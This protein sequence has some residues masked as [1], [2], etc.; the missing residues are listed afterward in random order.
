MRVWRLTRRRL[1][2]LSGEG[3]RRHGGRWTSPGRPVVYTAQSAALALL[4]VLVHLDLGPGL[5]PSDYVLMEIDAPDDL[6]VLRTGAR[7]AL[8]FETSRR[9]GDAWIAAGLEPVLAL[10]SVIVPRETNYLLNPR[11]AAAARLR[12]VGIDDFAIDRRLL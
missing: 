10:P 5:L 9:I 1:A 7:A 12:I 4:E 8:D 3:A 11:H 2:D 6:R